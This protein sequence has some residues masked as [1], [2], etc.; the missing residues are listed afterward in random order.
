MPRPKKPKRRDRTGTLA[1][2]H[3]R[4]VPHPKRI[5]E[6]EWLV[7]PDPVVEAMETVRFVTIYGM[8]EQPV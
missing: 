5:A 6:E 7:Q 1:E 8:Y 2:Q 4:L 3:H